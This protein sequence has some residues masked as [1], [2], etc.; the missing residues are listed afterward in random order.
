[1][2]KLMKN[3]SKYLFYGA[4]FAV[5]MGTASCS[6]DKDLGEP[7]SEV[8]VI[9]SVTLG[10]TR[11]NADARNLYMLPNQE[12]QLTCTVL[13]EE[14]EDKG[15]AWSVQNNSKDAAGN[16]VEAATVTPD[17]LVIAKEVGIAIVRATP[18]IGFGATDATPSYIVHVVDHFDYIE[19]FEVEN[20]TSLSSEGISEAATCQLEVTAFPENA[21]F[22]RYT[23]KSSDESLATVDKNGLITGMR[24]NG[25]ETKTVTV[26]VTADDFSSNPVSK[27][28]EVKLNPIVEPTAMDVKADAKDYLAAL[29]YGEQYDLRNA[30]TLTPAGATFELIEWT[31]SDKSVASVDANGILTVNG[32]GGTA[33][34]TATCG[35]M[36]ATVDVAI[37]GGRLWYSFAEMISSWYGDGATVSA[38]GEKTTVTLNNGGG[39]LRFDGDLSL[40]LDYPILAMKVMLPYQVAAG[41]NGR[42]TFFIETDFGRYNGST[43]SGNNVFTVVEG[44]EGEYNNSIPQTPMVCYFD[45]NNGFGGEKAD[46]PHHDLPATGVEVMEGFNFRCAD[47]NKVPD[48]LGYYEL[49]WVRSFKTVE[50]LQ[51]YLT[52]TENNNNE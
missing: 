41:S 44:Y 10:E 42:G 26:T 16:A 7:M 12:V 6:D 20:E 34:L 35:G 30:V 5:C 46:K 22:K 13:P 29:G 9:S 2:E 38:D 17:G 37:A 25:G 39:R 15:I 51:E 19:N 40:S 27:E 3:N 49:Y 23:F 31:S 8:T 28:I 18:A 50:D 21:T 33:T 45:L 4:A 48:N 47:F 52:G 36:T 1:M 24:A 32:M 11:Y 14:A 43:S